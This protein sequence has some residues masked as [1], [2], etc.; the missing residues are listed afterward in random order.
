MF[1][2]DRSQHICG[3]PQITGKNRFLIN[4][5]IAGYRTKIGDQPSNHITGFQF[6]FGHLRA[7]TC[8]NIDTL[9]VGISTVSKRP[10]G[11]SASTSTVA[12]RRAGILCGNTKVVDQKAPIID[13]LTNPVTTIIQSTKRKVCI[14]VAVDAE[15]RS[16]TKG[17]PISGTCGP[18]RW[19]LSWLTRWPLRWLTRWPLRWLTRRPFRWPLRGWYWCFRGPLRGRYWCFRG[20]LRRLFRGFSCIRLWNF[21]ICDAGWISRLR[22]SSRWR[23]RW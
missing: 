11:V 17:W 5:G 20:P 13:I 3:R 10:N 23:A 14:V 19:P 9:A 8:T 2:D 1:S 16:R 21:C 22:G 7:I 6:Q 4:T 18:N 15:F 12:D